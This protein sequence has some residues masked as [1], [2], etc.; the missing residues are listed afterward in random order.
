[1]IYLVDNHGNNPAH[2]V[3][4]IP[5]DLVLLYLF[6]CFLLFIPIIL[7]LFTP[8]PSLR[9]LQLI[10]IVFFRGN[11]FFF[12]NPHW[13]LNLELPVIPSFYYLSQT[14]RVALDISCNI[15]LQRNYIGHS[16]QYILPN[17]SLFLPTVSMSLLL[18]IV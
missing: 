2:V 7:C 8:I 3:Y 5:G 12:F 13:D 18:K 14:S 16:P 1:M 15:L 10:S 6:S 17:T 11:F 9:I 4:D